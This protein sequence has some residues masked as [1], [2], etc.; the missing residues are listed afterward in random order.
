MILQRALAVL[1]LLALVGCGA[2]GTPNPPASGLTVSGSV[3]T[4]LARDG[5]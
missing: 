5:G 3:E 2:E 1:S 4:G